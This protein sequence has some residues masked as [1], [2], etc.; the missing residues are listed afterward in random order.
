MNLHLFNSIFFLS[1]NPIIAKLSLFISYPFTYIG[2]IVLIIW[3]I[4]LSKRK[5]YDFSL[6]FLSG[7][8][9]WAVA[10]FIKNTLQIN[11]PHVD[12]DIIPLY[13]EIGFSFPSEHMAVYTAFTIS[14]F[15]INKKFGYVFLFF[16]I[17]VGVS[18]I[19][20]G[21]HYPVDILGGFFVGLIIS[22]IFT[23]LFKK[24]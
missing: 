5:M 12:L 20:I 19:I 21:V 24:I 16:S 13:K 9:S 1:N 23:E 18:R 10:S 8:F 7:F 17:I 11:R 4:F 15:L 2:I 6:F 3:A 14:M 22:L